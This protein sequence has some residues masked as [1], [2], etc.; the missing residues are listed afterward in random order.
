MNKIKTLLLTA[1]VIMITAG[2][3]NAQEVPVTPDTARALAQQ[4]SQLTQEPQ[5]EQS[6]G[7][8]QARTQ[9]GEQAQTQAGEKVQ[10]QAGEQAQNR[11]QSKGQPQS[12]NASGVKKVQSARP[13]WS[14]ARGARP[15]SIERPSGSRIPKGAGRPAGAKGPGRR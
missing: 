12:G 2:V 5:G 3:I 8:E 1:A 6:M 7:G 10:I 14:K 4:G 15:A 9:A 13:D 11:V